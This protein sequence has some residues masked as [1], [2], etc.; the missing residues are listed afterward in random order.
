[1]ARRDNDDERKAMKRP[2]RGAEKGKGE[3]EGK[4]EEAQRERTQESET[5]RA[6]RQ[7]GNAAIAAMMNNQEGGGRGGGAEVEMARRKVDHEKDGQDYG[8][9]DDAGDPGGFEEIDLSE[10]WNA[11]TTQPTDR[12]EFLEQMPD[13]ELPPEDD[14]WLASLPSEKKVPRAAAVAGMDPVVQPSP[15]ILARSIVGWCRAAARM[16]GVEPHR[17]AL[18]MLFVHPGPLLQ[19]PS[20]R[21]LLLRARTAA[22]SVAAIASGPLAQAPDPLV[23]P[24]AR[25]LLELEA[26]D[27]LVRA[28]RIQLGD[29]QRPQAR[30]LAQQVLEGWSG[31]GRLAELTPATSAW[32]DASL[33][34]LVRL[35]SAIGLVPRFPEP[36]IEEEEDDPLGLDAFMIEQTGGAKDPHEAVYKAAIQAAE[37]LAAALFR[38]RLRLVG[39]GAAVA[40]LAVT[41]AE[42]NVAETVFELMGRVDART[43]QTMILLREVAKA[44]QKRQVAPSGL[45]NGLLRAARDLDKA[46]ADT[47]AELGALVAGLIPRTPEIPAPLEAPD[48]ALAQ[49]WGDGQP[50]DAIPW[51]ASLPAS[52]H[53]DAAIA[54]TRLATSASPEEEIDG[55]LALRARA[56]DE[57]EPLLGYAAGVCAGA[58]SLHLGRWDDAAALAEEHVALGLTRR[59]GVFVA[60]GALLAIEARVGAGDLEGAEAVRKKLGA[61]LWKM[62][63]R[64]A[65]TL[66]ARWTPPSEDDWEMPVPE[67]EPPMPDSVDVEAEE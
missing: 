12:P 62:G 39:T 67:P 19:D 66:L 51:L 11:G 47:R 29:N 34:A 44:A 22:L 3:E 41:V 1:V 32:L 20:G 60:E 42:A 30:P 10:S 24:F 18:A 36:R 6:H 53:R 58:V 14:P 37:R 40:D 63:A 28:A 23:G 49:A 54:F 21:V 57:G 56:A 15:E 2:D 64:G 26:R 46:R 31:E 5:S 52:L 48:D 43:E 45:R 35:E 25:L 16:T 61:A 33:D 8:G 4:D 9:E 55:L 59:N 7:L 50:D 17:R 13:D 38:V 65:L 27:N